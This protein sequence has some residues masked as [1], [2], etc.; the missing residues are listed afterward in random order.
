MD[1]DDQEGIYC[2]DDGEYRK[3]CYICRKYSTERFYK[4]DLRQRTHI[5]K[6]RKIDQLNKIFQ[7]ISLY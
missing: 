6:I 3:Y 4:N 2:E 1:S 5:N 7:K